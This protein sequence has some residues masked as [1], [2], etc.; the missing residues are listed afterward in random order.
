LHILLVD[1]HEE[2]RSTTAAMLSD[3][4]HEV[5]EAATGTEA[6]TALKSGNCSYDLMITD[7][8]MPHV[9]GAEFLREARAFC[10]G[11]PALMITGYADADAIS[12]R[13]EAVEILLK[14]F[15]PR[16]L[17]EAIARVCEA[18]VSAD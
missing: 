14:P 7:Y 10:P 8:A 4:G 2:V 12:D 9:S 3:F 5:V 11:V 17:E 1:D 13:P 15:T 16:K 18:K 6:L